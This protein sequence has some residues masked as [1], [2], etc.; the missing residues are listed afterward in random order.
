[1]WQP[2]ADQSV[3]AGN[4]LTFTVQA[5]DPDGTIPSLS[6]T[7]LPAGASFVDN[8]DGTGTFDWTPAVG[9]AGTYVLTCTASDGELSVSQDVTITVLAATYTITATPGANGTITPSGAVTVEHGAAQS[10]TIT[11]D[12]GY[13]IVEIRVDGQGRS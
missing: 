4:P 13:H 5:D 3:L 1:V 2:I 11:P 12:E 6:A 10:F 9:D 7:P 8:G